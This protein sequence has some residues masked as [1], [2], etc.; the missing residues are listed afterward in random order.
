MTT[1]LLITD[2]KKYFYEIAEQ[3]SNDETNNRVQW[4]SKLKLVPILLS[5]LKSISLKLSTL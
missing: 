4:T 2:S 3:G 1:T 5:I